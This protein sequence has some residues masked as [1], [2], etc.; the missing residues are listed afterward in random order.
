MTKDPV[1]TENKENEGRINRGGSWF[2]EADYFDVSHR[3]D[4][5]SPDDR[6]N[7][8]GFRLVRNVK[9]KK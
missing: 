5:D 1:Q 4:D 7:R 8:V 3:H 6:N 9:E 2:N